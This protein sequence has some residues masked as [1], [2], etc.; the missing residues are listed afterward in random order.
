MHLAFIPHV[1]VLRLFS[2]QRAMFSGF[3]ALLSIWHVIVHT[4]VIGC[5]VFRRHLSYFL[6]QV[7]IFLY[8][9]SFLS[10]LWQLG[11]TDG[12]SCH[13]RT[14]WLGMYTH[15]K[16]HVK[17]EHKRLIRGKRPTWLFCFIVR[18]DNVARHMNYLHGVS[19]RTVK[20]WRNET[21]ST[22]STA[23]SNAVHAL[24]LTFC[25]KSLSMSVSKIDMI[26][27]RVRCL[28]RIARMA[29]EA[30]AMVSSCTNSQSK[31]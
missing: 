14:S 22:V 4:I 12:S 19:P 11:G 3:D 25:A 29:V 15:V 30:L 20:L 23:I 31:V 7:R 26:A 28:S 24:A 2:L 16:L 21:F 27:R 5:K 8:I 6:I 13:W 10:C 18:T 9:C 1:C 17:F